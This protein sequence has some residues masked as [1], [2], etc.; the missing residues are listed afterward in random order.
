M[1][2]PDSDLSSRAI[3]VLHWVDLGLAIALGALTV[4]LVVMWWTGRAT[5]RHGMIYVLIGAIWIGPSAP[6]FWLAARA[7]QR[8]WRSRW[9]LQVL[10]FVWPLTFIYL[11]DQAFG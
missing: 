6:L 9:L 7:M 2:R 11:F 3:A 4:L 10:P 5:D 1:R 8:Q